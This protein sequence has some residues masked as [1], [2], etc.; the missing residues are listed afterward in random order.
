M[1]LLVDRQLCER[2]SD[3]LS[4]KIEEVVSKFW[5]ED[6]NSVVA[7]KV[8]EKARYDQELRGLFET[9]EAPDAT[10]ENLDFDATP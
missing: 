6:S 10:G 5:C 7:K 4:I 1:Y 8:A 3:N 2:F 9:K